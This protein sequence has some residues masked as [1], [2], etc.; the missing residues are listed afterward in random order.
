MKRLIRRGARAVREAVA[1]A[2]L[3]ADLLPRLPFGVAI[4]VAA[5]ALVVALEHDPRTDE[6]VVTVEE[7]PSGPPTLYEGEYFEEEAE[8][9]L[10]EY[11]F[12]KV[13]DAH[14]RERILAAAVVRNPHDAQ[15]LPG[16]LSIHT[17]TASGY[18]RTLEDIYIGIMAP[19]ST[20]AVGYVV[21]ADV[22]GIEPEDLQLKALDSTMLYPNVSWE[23]EEV[24]APNPLPEVEFVRTEPLTSPDG[25]RVHFR[26]ESAAAAVDMHLSVLFRD[27]EGRLL[28]GMPATSDP[29]SIESGIGGAYRAVPAGESFQH[30]DLHASWIP[31]GADLDRI[32]IGPSH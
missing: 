4:A 21:L 7:L 1:R 16:G 8:L 6:N 32:E 5:V 11:G 28:G 31:D 19:E 20:A 23:T 24:F 3:R 14:G 22:D 26:T 25:Y 29:M 17:E 15:L 2:H 18:P 12:S 9:E 30:F 10:L 13:T 27:G